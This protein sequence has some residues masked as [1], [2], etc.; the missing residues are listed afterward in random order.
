[1]K[2]SRMGLIALILFSLA[3]LAA[4]ELVYRYLN[5][6]SDSLADSGPGSLKRGLERVS[7]AEILPCGLLVSLAL[8]VFAWRERQCIA[9]KA[10]NALAQ[11]CPCEEGS[12]DG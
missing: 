4:G 7:R 9:A 1:M 12:T 10:A 11:C 6:L 2:V 8:W 5:F 3:G